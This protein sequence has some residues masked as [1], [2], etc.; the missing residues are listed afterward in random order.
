M[1]I[2]FST[3]VLIVAIE[4]G[5]WGPAR[6]P[7]SLQQA[8]LTVAALCPGDNPLAATRYLDRLYDLPDTRS[9]RRM[10][11]RLARAIENCRPR[12]IVPGDE[13]TVAFLQSLVRLGATRTGKLSAAALDLI[14]ASLGPV[15][16]FDAMLLKSHTLNLARLLSV[17]VP[18][19]ETVAT[20]AEAQRAATR[21]GY[22]V[23]LKTSFG[24][25]GQGMTKCS[26]AAE[27]S[28][29]MRRPDD[30]PSAI[31][32]ACRRLLN[33]DWYPVRTPCDVQQ[34]IVGGPAMYCAFAWQGRML[35]GFAG[36][37]Q[38]TCSETGPSTVV[39]LG[40]QAEMAEAAAKMIAGLGCTGF[41]GFDFM[42][43]AETGLAYLL[44]CNPRPIQVSHLGSLV[45]AGLAAALASVLG[46]IGP[47]EPV[48]PVAGET[49][50][51]RDLCKG[52]VSEVVGM[53]INKGLL[54][55]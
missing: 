23:Y 6:L 2:P 49:I 16:R 3:D 25:A 53:V 20:T 8:G 1:Q 43:E 7:R 50:H 14:A 47:A 38:Q 31:K 24:W 52:G 37:P 22:P 26:D 51:G 9:C 41:V 17:R 18:S 32:A 30:R 5:R 45:G 48:L 55:C 15:E 36:I 42:L 27:L 19:S 40:Q 46:V 10:A 54:S 21:T 33:R 35:A 28:S 12:L 39:W 34:V 44:E 4:A 29:A 13:R 11:S